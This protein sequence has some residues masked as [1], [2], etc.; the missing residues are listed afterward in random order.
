LSPPTVGS[1]CSCDAISCC[2]LTRAHKSYDQYATSHRTDSFDDDF[3]RELL[4]RKLSSTARK[5]IADVAARTGLR[6]ASCQ[7]Q[8]GNFRRLFDAFDAAKDEHADSDS[9]S[10]DDDARDAPY[11]G[12]AGDVGTVTTAPGAA[13]AALA[14]AAS[15]HVVGVGVGVGGDILRVSADRADDA[16][17]AADD[18]AAAAAIGSGRVPLLA[19]APAIQMQGVYPVSAGL[20]FAAEFCLPLPLARRYERLAFACQHRVSVR[21]HHVQPILFRLFLSLVCR[22]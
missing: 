6:E 1:E 3:A 9:D 13:A 14:L 15:P 11:R 18:G 19:L 16:A 10:D 12:A 5:Q 7:R 22:Y 2:S 8:F 21:V 4:G 17:A 20:F